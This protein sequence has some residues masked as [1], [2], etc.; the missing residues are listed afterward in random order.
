[1]T[2]LR[3]CSMGGKHR[4]LHSNRLASSFISPKSSML[5]SSSLTDTF[6]NITNITTTNITIYSLVS[7]T[8]SN[9]S[10]SQPP[11]STFTCQIQPPAYGAAYNAQGGGISMQVPM[12]APRWPLSKMKNHRIYPTKNKCNKQTYKQMLKLGVQI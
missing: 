12:Q 9:S 4:Q 6:I 10:Q 2:I 8:Q 7:V 1:M 3:M 11:N 5:W